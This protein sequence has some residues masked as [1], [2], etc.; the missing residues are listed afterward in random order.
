MVSSRR[1]MSRGVFACPGRDGAVVPRV[2]RLEHVERLAA[3]AFSDDDAVRAHPQGIADE[4]AY[5]DGAAP[6]DVGRPGFQPD[7]VRLL[8]ADF[9]RVLY[10]DDPLLLGDEAGQGVQQGGL[11]RNRFRP[12]R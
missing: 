3:A 8:K 10:G 9:G 1:S 12:R 5:G 11:A 6:L 2:H 4:I 7:H